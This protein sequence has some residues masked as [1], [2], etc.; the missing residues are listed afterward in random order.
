MQ[1]IVKDIYN[2][3]KSYDDVKIIINKMLFDIIHEIEFNNTY[4]R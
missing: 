2:K 1:Y 4:L 3:N